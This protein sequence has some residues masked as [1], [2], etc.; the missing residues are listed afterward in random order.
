MDGCRQPSLKLAAPNS[1]KFKFRAVFLQTD[2][3]APV[4]L[5]DSCQNKKRAKFFKKATYDFVTKK[6]KIY[7]SNLKS[8]TKLK[9]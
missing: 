5:P 9:K 2:F 7:Q 1:R 8:Y 4:V 3:A 6:W